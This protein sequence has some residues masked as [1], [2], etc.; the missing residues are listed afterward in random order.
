M[1]W[2]HKRRRTHKRLAPK[3][4]PPEGYMWNPIPAIFGDSPMVPI[5][6]V[7]TAAKQ[8]YESW[9]ASSRDYR[10][11]HQSTHRVMAEQQTLMKLRNAGL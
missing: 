6:V 8:L 3:P 4:E 7:E 9:D 2:H 1:I 10:M 11:T 5:E